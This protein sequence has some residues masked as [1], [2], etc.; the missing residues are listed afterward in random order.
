[1]ITTFVRFSEEKKDN[2]TIKRGRGRKS[3]DY[4]AIFRNYGLQTLRENEGGG[5]KEDV[6]VDIKVSSM[7]VRSGELS[8][9][10]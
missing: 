3:A 5:P 10:V 8:M 7:A 6:D 9:S 1:M 2:S 4:P